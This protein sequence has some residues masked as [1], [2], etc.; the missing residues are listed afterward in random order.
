MAHA[1]CFFITLIINGVASLRAYTRKLPNLIPNYLVA[2]GC[3]WIPGNCRDLQQPV[4][5]SFVC[6]CTPAG[7]DF[8]VNTYTSKE[9]NDLFSY[10]HIVSRHTMYCSDDRHDGDGVYHMCGRK[11]NLLV[12]VSLIR[13]DFLYCTDAFVQTRRYI[14]NSDT[15]W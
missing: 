10:M 2:R 8:I 5:Y 1:M 3:I 12:V 11:E 6:D 14:L 9:S 7:V 15:M 4:I 13:D